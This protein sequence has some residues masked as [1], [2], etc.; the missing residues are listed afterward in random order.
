MPGAKQLSV[1][2]PEVVIHSGLEAF[3][4]LF[5]NALAEKK[6]TRVD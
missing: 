4:C 2:L 6:N 5:G 1:Y 3:E